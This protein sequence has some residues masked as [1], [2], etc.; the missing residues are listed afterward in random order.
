VTFG[1]RNASGGKGLV[2]NENRTGIDRH[3]QLSGN[4]VR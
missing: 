1:D 3:G 4:R 2:C